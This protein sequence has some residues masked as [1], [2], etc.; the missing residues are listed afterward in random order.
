MDGYYSQSISQKKRTLLFLAFSL[1]M[2]KIST[3]S[4]VTPI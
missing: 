2:E 4:L 1:F 3:Q